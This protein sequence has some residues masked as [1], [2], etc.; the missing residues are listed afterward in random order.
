MSTTDT[1]MRNS[2]GKRVFLYDRHMLETD[3]TDDLAFL[4]I[5][6]HL[7]VEVMLDILA[8]STFP[9]PKYLDKLD[10]GFRSL[11]FVVRAAVIKKSDDSHWDLIVKLNELRN[12]FAH[13]LEPNVETKL[14]E[15]FRIHDKIYGPSRSI[16]DSDCLR[17][18]VRHCMEFLGS[19]NP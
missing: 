13:N 3:D 8:H 12:K 6:G 7:L 9:H 5:K 15:L 4:V 14:R 10:L 17:Q 2:K 16:G 1:E 18:V 11:A 19:L